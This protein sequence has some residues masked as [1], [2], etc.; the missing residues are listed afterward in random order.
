M[1]KEAPGVRFAEVSRETKE[2]RVEVVLD[3]DGGTRQD[4]STGVGFFDH[5]LQQSAFHG[6][7]DVGI[8]AEGDLF[9]DDHHTVEDVGI[10]LGQAIHRALEKNDGIVR[11]SSINLVMDD[12]LILC[13]MDIGGRG[14]L[15][16]DIPFTREKIG[17]LSMENVKE[18]FKALAVNSGIT[19]HLK[20]LSGEN[21][22]H[23]CEATF[24]AFGIALHQATRQSERRL[25]SSTK[26]KRGS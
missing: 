10:V 13:A 12:A 25:S 2:T 6:L 3:L 20:K 21:D 17:D 22:H 5:M 7:F 26:G 18:F 11:Y 1:S 19:L 16:Y 23:V 8:Q 14:A 9:I 24:K 15:H 4:I